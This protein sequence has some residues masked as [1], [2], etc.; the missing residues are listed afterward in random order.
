MKIG[1][2]CLASVFFS[3]IT[4]SC[5]E[6]NMVD[7]GFKLRESENIWR[8]RVDSLAMSGVLGPNS[9]IYY[10]NGSYTDG[11]PISLTFSDREIAGSLVLNEDQ[12]QYGPLRNFY[13]RLGQD[14]AC[15]LDIFAIDDSCKTM[16]PSVGF[17][18]LED[19]R[20]F[21]EAVLN[22]F[23]EP[24]SAAIEHVFENEVLNEVGDTI[25]KNPSHHSNKLTLPSAEGLNMLF[26]PEEQL[27]K[28][29]REKLHVYN[30]RSHYRTKK[31]TSTDKLE[32]LKTGLKTY[33]LYWTLGSQMVSYHAFATRISQ[34]IKLEDDYGF[35]ELSIYD[36]ES[37]AL[38]RLVEDSVYKSFKPADL[39]EIRDASVEWVRP[40]VEGY[41][42]GLRTHMSLPVRLPSIIRKPITNIKIQI[43]L[44]D[45]Y[46]DEYTRL[47]PFDYK[48]N[49]DLLDPI[50]SSKVNTNI[51]HPKNYLDWNYNPSSEYFNELEDLR[52]LSQSQEIKV[53]IKALA[54]RFFRWNSY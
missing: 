39:V 53:E 26:A 46:G 29:K 31:V 33:K 50:F 19:E 37:D 13:L 7:L 4:L 32:N 49:Q 34:R 44:Q 14:S 54:I 6:N 25:W 30:S 3:F 11:Y 5:M 20:T 35:V 9:T 8:S 16:T 12:Y 17:L 15:V 24:D 2:L 22:Q 36:S 43:V 42:W 23:G 21:R 1:R 40:E 45:A 27:E 48:L 38:Y 52:I 41:K 47:K 28:W 10:L 18:S 51:T